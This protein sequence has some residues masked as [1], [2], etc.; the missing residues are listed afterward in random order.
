MR[1][2]NFPDITLT[3]SIGVAVPC[4]NCVHNVGI[5]TPV[6]FAVRKGLFDADA[7]CDDTRPCALVGAG[8]QRRRDFESECP[9]SLEVEAAQNCAR[10]RV[11]ITDTGPRSRL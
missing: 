5:V 2:P 8:E 10:R 6:N 4:Q 1:D 9:G 3:S 7:P 11:A